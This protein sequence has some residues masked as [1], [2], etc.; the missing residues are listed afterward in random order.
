MKKAT[1]DPWQMQEEGGGPGAQHKLSAPG[2]VLCDQ[3]I[4][5]LMQILFIVFRC[6]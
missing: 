3:T 6:P 2:L 4:Q 5:Q 1:S